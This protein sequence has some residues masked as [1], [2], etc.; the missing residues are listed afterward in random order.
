MTNKFGL[1]YLINKNKEVEPQARQAQVGADAEYV[2]R[3]TASLGGII[4]MELKKRKDAGADSV[5]LFEL[6]DALNVD[7]DT[8]GL[9]VG[10]LESLSLVS[11]EPEKYG[12][13]SVRLTKTGEDSLTLSSP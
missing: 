4:L 9:V 6:V 1:D 7:R 8:L 13:H 12:N 10:R 11:V 2:E 3:A 5:K